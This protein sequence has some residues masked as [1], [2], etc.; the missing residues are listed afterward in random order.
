MDRHTL[1]DGVVLFSAQDA[2]VR[3]LSVLGRDVAGRPWHTTLLV[4][5][6]LED[7]LYSVPLAFFAM[8]FLLLYFDFT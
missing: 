2:H 8:I 3:I 6:A 7:D 4:L 1:E 5:S